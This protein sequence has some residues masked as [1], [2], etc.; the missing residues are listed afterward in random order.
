MKSRDLQQSDTRSGPDR[1]RVLHVCTRYLRGGSE[2]RLRDFIAAVPDV[3]HDVVIGLESDP[4]LAR[5]QLDAASISVEPALIRQ[6]SPVRDAIAVAR[7]ARRVRRGGYVLVVTHQSKAGVVG[8][9]AA[10]MAGRVPVIHSLS[11]ASFGP[12]YSARSSRIQRATERVLAPLTTG[13]AVVGTDLAARYSQIGIDE[14]K[15]RIVRSGV[16]LPDHRVA[17]SQARRHL[18]ERFGIDRTAPLIAYLGSLDER[19]GVDELP[20]ILDRVRRGE[21]AARLVI[22]GAGSLEPLLRSRFAADLESSTVYML[23]HVSPVDDLVAAADVIVLPSRVE[24]ISQ[25]LIQAAVAATP[26]VAYEVDGVQELRDL[27]AA[28]MS[29]PIGDRDRLSGAIVEVLRAGFRGAPIDA[30]DW[31]SDKIAED[32]RSLFDS[33][34]PAYN[35]RVLV[36]P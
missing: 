28:A 4:D 30:G 23:G 19:K 7:L 6:V 31:A 22:A 9:T 32:Y 12:G 21:P 29:A 34:L 35:R 11:M 17:P 33:V 8:R 36:A 15:L 1:A 2:R 3:I 18:H 16:P 20:A 27:G 5:S 10:A 24:G 26:F 13:Y 14:R 25:V